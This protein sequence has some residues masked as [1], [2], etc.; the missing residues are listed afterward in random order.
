MRNYNYMSQYLEGDGTPVNL[1]SIYD[2]R[3]SFYG[4]AQVTGE[5][6]G[7]DYIF[8]LYSYGTL[9]ATAKEESDGKLSCTHLGRFSQTTSR[10]QREFFHQLGLSINEIRYL[11]NHVDEEVNFE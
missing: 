9:V 6:S 1:D 4:K 10:H 11:E 8:K 5:K 2:A 7:E 3:Q